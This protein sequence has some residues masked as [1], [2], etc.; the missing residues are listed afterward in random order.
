MEIDQKTKNFIEQVPFEDAFTKYPDYCK[1]SLDK[2]K[3]LFDDGRNLVINFHE[4]DEKKVF[5]DFKS[6]II[7]FKIL[8]KE[9]ETIK[10]NINGNKN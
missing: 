3:Y 2:I 5:S 1:T 4:E 7:W 10:G 9:H 8:I 6:F